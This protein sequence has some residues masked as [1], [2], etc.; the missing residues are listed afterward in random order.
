[1]KILTTCIVL[2]CAAT[3]SA[4]GTLGDLLEQL[5]TA[6][7]ASINPDTGSTPAEVQP[8]AAAAVA[9]PPPPATSIGQGENTG[10][11]LSAPKRL[12]FH[13][14]NIDVSEAFI[15]LRQITRR[16]VVIAPGIDLRFTGDLYDMGFDEAVE[17]IAESVGLALRRRGSVLFLEPPEVETRVYKLH[18]SRAQELVSMIQPL[19]G[20]QGFVSGTA[21]ALQGI[22]PDSESAGSDSFAQSD[23]IMVRDLPE[24]LDIVGELIAV[25]DARPQQVLV[26]ATILSAKL[27]DDL[28]FGVNL[29]KLADA[30]FLEAGA[31]SP[32]GTSL[33]VPTQSSATINEGFGIVDTNVANGLS[34]G[35]LNVAFLSGR[36]GAFL[37]AVQTL[38]DTTVLAN[39]KILTLNKQRGEVLLG[40]RDGYITSTTTQTSTTEEV[41]F[42]ETGTRLIFRPFVGEGGMVRMEIHPED[43]EGGL[44]DL[45]LPFEETTEVTTNVMVRSGQTVIVGGLFR[46]RLRTTKTKVPWLGDLPLLG[47]LFRSTHDERVREEIIVMLTPHIVDTEQLGRESTAARSP[48]HERA[49]RQIR[50]DLP[51]ARHDP[52]AE[53]KLR[54]MLLSHGLGEGDDS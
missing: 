4:Q 51:Q 38:T 16:N 48:E 26:E 3:A 10:F 53:R 17:V 43:S 41:E 37:R 46:E 25:V 13:A 5:E 20:E 11:E 7:N 8:V 6:S 19:L 28:Q 29:S 18:Y 27:E 30:D 50:R 52:R 49:L 44:N 54:A 47:W 32:N 31:T 14:R 36:V 35:G 23:V 12:E 39:P 40:R 45:G 22:A 34:T 2:L 21:E 15:Q 9:A 33:N 24:V 42:L 1:M